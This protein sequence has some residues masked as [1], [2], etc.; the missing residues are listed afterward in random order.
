METYRFRDLHP[1][2]LLGTASDR[3]AGWLGQVYTR[4]KYP[5][6]LL[7]RT[8]KLGTT[9]FKE[10]LLPIE[11]VAEYFEHFPVLEIDFTFYEFLLDAEG[12]PTKTFQ[13]LQKYRK[14]ISPD[15]SLILK[16]PQRISAQK[17]RHGGAFLENPDYL[18]P[19]AFVS[20]FFKPA[21][22]LLGTSLR[23]FVF[24][25]EYQRKQ[26]RVSSTALARSLDEFFSGVPA[27]E[28]YH[29]ELR[30]ESYLTD[31]LLQV[32][33][34]HGA[35]QVLSHW[36]WLP[37]LR[38]QFALSGDRFHNAGRQAVIRLLTPLG[39]RYENAYAKAFP[40]DKVVAE[41]LQ[42]TM[43]EETVEL[44]AEAVKAGVTINVIANNRAGG[45]APSIALKIARRFLESFPPRRSMTDHP[46]G[47]GDKIR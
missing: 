10:T 46:G 8:R 28:R 36:T 21:C 9:S 3:Y 35:G 45:N 15:D 5:G 37:R 16:A 11:S 20:R 30:T 26:D 23:A 29:V 13:A 34:K 18:N 2:L 39:M 4:E 38:K 41:M 44:M 40:F 24:E 27:D 1:R 19:D 14:F 43:L 42:P 17:I 31:V 25:Q 22:E 12:K 47:I 33:E 6:P 32:L 7:T